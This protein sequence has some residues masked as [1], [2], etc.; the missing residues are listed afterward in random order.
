MLKYKL[1]ILAY[2]IIIGH[3]NAMK[4]IIKYNNQKDII[5]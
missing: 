3:K 1:L 5:N 4:R 2:Y